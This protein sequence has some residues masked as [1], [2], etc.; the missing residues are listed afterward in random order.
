MLPKGYRQRQPRAPHLSFQYPQV[1][2][3]VSAQPVKCVDA[4]RAKRKNKIPSKERREMQSMQSHNVLA[5][6][7]KA[8]SYNLITLLLCYDTYKLLLESYYLE[9]DNSAPFSLLLQLYAHAHKK[10]V[11]PLL[12]RA[13]LGS[14]A[15]HSTARL[16]AGLGAAESSPAV[17]CRMWVADTA[18]Q[19]GATPPSPPSTHLM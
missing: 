6:N 10:Q 18:L 8:Q 14:M 13:F 12:Q 5:I 7:F 4:S 3:S 11:E 17:E 19:M 16:P 1:L 9:A 15:P 2:T